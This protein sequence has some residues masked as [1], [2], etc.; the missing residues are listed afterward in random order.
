MS[1]ITIGGTT[2]NVY[3][4]VAEADD[5]FQGSTDFVTWGAYTNA[6]RERGLITATRLL[7]R[8][9]WLG[10]KADD[11][12]DL[13]FPRTGLS[14][15]AGNELTEA[16]TLS[17]VAEASQLLAFDLLGGSTV[18]T[19]GT[20]EALTKRLKADT[21]EIEYFRGDSSLATRFDKDVMELIGCFLSNSG[22]SSNAGSIAYGTDGTALDDDYSFYTG[23]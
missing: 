19:S 10:A 3:S 12:Q 6:E 18:Q 17:T 13:K 1:T 2:Y 23:F 9:S 14:D 20:N 5:Y 8:Q 15:C 7:E 16:E 4:T 22:S 11:D 21:V